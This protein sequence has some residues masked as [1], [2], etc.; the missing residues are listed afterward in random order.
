MSS[1]VSHMFHLFLISSSQKCP[2]SRWER[3][4]KLLTS[5]M[6]PGPSLLSLVCFHI[7]CLQSYIRFFWDHYLRSR[8][9]DWP[10]QHTGM[11][12]FTMS[13][14]QDCTGRKLVKCIVTT[15][16]CSSQ[17]P[18]ASIDD[19]PGS[20]VRVNPNE[21]H[22]DDPDFYN[23]IYNNKGKWNKDNRAARQFWAMG[24]IASTANHDIHKG[25][26]SVLDSYF[27][28]GKIDS[29]QPTV[30]WH[31]EKMC[32]RINRHKQQ[33]KPVP[34]NL[35]FAC[36]AADIVT[37][38]LMPQSYYLLDTPDFSPSYYGMMRASSQF[39]QFAKNIWWAY[40]VLEAVPRWFGRLFSKVGIELIEDQDVSQS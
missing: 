14:S 6:S 30:I 37:S 7:T 39:S 23:E 16:Q 38:Y 10:P 13:T 32:S 27:A 11:K 40:P 21:I 1:Y 4:P 8:G 35:A 36:M 31:L 3:S 26:R 34:L 2:S 29:L 25:R 33:G 24:S 20:I 12:C 28:R 18:D 5:T 9:L 15:V 17:Y 22:I 19:L